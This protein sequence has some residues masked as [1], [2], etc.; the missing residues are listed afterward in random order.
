RKTTAK[1]LLNKGVILSLLRREQEA[2]VVYN[3]IADRFETAIEPAVRALVARA[4]WYKG[5]DLR[6]LAERETSSQ[7]LEQ[8]LDVYIDIV[9]RRAA[10][11]ILRPLAEG[12]ASQLQ[13]LLEALAEPGFAAA[14]D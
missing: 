9:S 8:A 1:S 10:D 7:R 13:D 6:A 5:C 2:I 11:P 12:A 4:L 14:L 3:E